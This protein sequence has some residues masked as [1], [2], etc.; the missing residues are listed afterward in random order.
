MRKILA[1]LLLLAVCAAFTGLGT[2]T[3]NGSLNLNG[4]LVAQ[5]KG[6]FPDSLRTNGP[7]TTAG[8]VVNYGKIIGADSLRV[9][10]QIISSKFNTLPDNTTPSV[11]G[12]NNWKCTPAGATTITTFTGGTSGQV[13]TIVFTNANATLSDAGTLKLNGGFTS[14]ADDVMTLVYDGTNWYEVSRS[15]N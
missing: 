15:V 4:D 12:A 5:G 2:Y 14:T 3:L 9:L 6:V 1:L 13:V 8:C 10:G 11:A 7:L